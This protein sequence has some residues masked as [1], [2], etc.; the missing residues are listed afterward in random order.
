MQFLSTT[1]RG[2]GIR[3][4]TP[5]DSLFPNWFLFLFC[6]LYC[7]QSPLSPKNRIAHDC[8]F[9]SS[10][11]G[12][13]AGQNYNLSFRGRAKGMTLDRAGLRIQASWPQLGVT[14]GKE[15]QLHCLS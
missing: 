3:L 4:L 11:S 13:P 10:G 9:P 14:V 6:F 5:A 7:L 8:F 15:A 1:T 2:G 12:W